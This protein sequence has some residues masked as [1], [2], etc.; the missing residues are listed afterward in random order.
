MHGSSHR[1]PGRQVTATGF[2]WVLTFPKVYLGFTLYPSVLKPLIR[3]WLMPSL[4]TPSALEAPTGTFS[5]WRTQVGP[6][7]HSLM[8]SEMVAPLLRRVAPFSLR[9]GWDPTSL[10]A[11]Y[12]SNSMSKLGT[13]F[14]GARRTFLHICCSIRHLQSPFLQ[15]G[16]TKLKFLLKFIGWW[17]GGLREQEMQLSREQDGR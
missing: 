12:S 7:Y 4:L 9:L 10:P 14:L 5:L 6:P 17:V 1:K 11:A 13:S 2:S 3:D 16:S 15:K 8:G